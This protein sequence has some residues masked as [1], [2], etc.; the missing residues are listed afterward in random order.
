MEKDEKQKPVD[1]R[2]EMPSWVPD[3]LKSK[4]DAPGPKKLKKKAPGEW[5]PP[6]VL[7]KVKETQENSGEPVKPPPYVPPNL[8]EDLQK[9]PSFITEERKRIDKMKSQKEAAF[10]KTKLI[11][12]L[13]DAAALIYAAKHAPTADLSLGDN[14]KE[15]NE[16]LNRLNQ[17]VSDLR[18]GVSQ[19]VDVYRQAVKSARLEKIRQAE[20]AQDKDFQRELHGAREKKAQARQDAANQKQAAKDRRK[21]QLETMK[22]AE[23]LA[24]LKAD[25]IAEGDDGDVPAK[26][27]AEFGMYLTPEQ[28]KKVEKSSG[29]LIDDDVE[30]II[31]GLPSSEEMAEVWARKAYGP[32]GTSGTTTA[33]AKQAR[34]EELTARKNAL[35]GN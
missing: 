3:F 10:S 12:D 24:T 9:L 19:E 18:K 7:P 8:Y 11:K 20:R 2:A 28:L 25:I 30:D 16:K 1:E 21:I 23:Q 13:I 32:L 33:Q 34:I 15:Y 14:E 29:Y 26:I 35:K 4:D 17:E 27:A 6:K 22:T 31:A 5:H